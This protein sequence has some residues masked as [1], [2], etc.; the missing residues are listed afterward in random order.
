MAGAAEAR[1]NSPGWLQ[2]SFLLPT[3]KLINSG[4]W[5][6]HRVGGVTPAPVRGASRTPTNKVS[7]LWLQ[8]LCV[9]VPLGH[10][11]FNFQTRTRSYCCRRS[12]C[13]GRQ[14]E[15]SPPPRTYT[16]YT[17]ALAAVTIVL[18]TLLVP[19]APRSLFPQGSMLWTKSQRTV[20]R[21]QQATPQQQHHQQTAHFNS[22]AL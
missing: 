1:E 9:V 6:Q 3:Y 10:K 17:L 8:L 15:R 22:S 2:T 14:W 18:L 4:G 21:R 19:V 13:G 7:T 12:E 11:N 5:A 20:N 16:L